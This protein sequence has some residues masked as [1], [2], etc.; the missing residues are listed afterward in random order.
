[1]QDGWLHHHLNTG[2][3]KPQDYMLTRWCAV[4]HSEIHYSAASK[5]KLYKTHNLTD[6]YIMIDNCRM[7]CEFLAEDNSDEVM[8]KLAELVNE[9]CN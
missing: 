5:E 1:M 4:C 6:E 9:I 7:L 3:K 2:G 8:N